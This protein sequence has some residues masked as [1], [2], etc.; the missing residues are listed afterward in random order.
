M[1]ALNKEIADALRSDQRL[2]DH[3]QT[4]C[5]A[6]VTFEEEEGYN[7]AC[8]LQEQVDDGILPSHFD[9][10]LTEK[11]DMTPATEPSDIIW[12]NRY[13]TKNQRRKKRCVVFISVLLMLAASGSV[14]FKLS[15][16]RHQSKNKYPPTN[17][18]N[19]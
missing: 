16:M 5:S 9:Y 1:Q 14:I 6:F 15:T 8:L 12:E 4:P 18:Q 7:R 3:L 13:F 17:C 19:A 10:L 11:L 2:L